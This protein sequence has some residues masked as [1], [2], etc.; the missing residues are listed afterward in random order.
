MIKKSK[1]K[2]VNKKQ[3]VKKAIKDKKYEPHYLAIILV[4][5]LLLEGYFISS[6]QLSDWKKGM[7]ILDV[8]TA[9][10]Q[11][12][13]DLSFVMQPVV[14]AVSGVDQFYQLSANAMIGMLDMSSDGPTDQVSHVAEGVYQFYQQASVQMA[15]MLDISSVSSWPASVAGASI[16]AE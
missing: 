9:V 4:G 1:N 8:S 15:D 11:T 12:T 2:K 13:S 16:V 7:G 10:T 5:L 14:D 3:A 6:T